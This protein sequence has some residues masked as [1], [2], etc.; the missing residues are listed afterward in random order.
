MKKL[1][2]CGFLFLFSVP[3]VAAENVLPAP[4]QTPALTAAQRK[5]IF[6][7]RRKQ[8]KQLVKKYKKASAQ[9]KPAIKQELSALVGEQVDA[10]LMYMKNRIQ[11]ERA[12]LDNWE[13]KIKQDEENLPAVKAQR[14]EEILSGTA[15]QKF[16]QAR[17]KWK[18]ELK[19]KRK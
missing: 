17:K 8:I 7:A 4:P 1:L 15:K 11:E 18:K 9:E 5:A 13:A 16:K 12:N 3:F 10:G 2:L 6:K 19:N 14:V